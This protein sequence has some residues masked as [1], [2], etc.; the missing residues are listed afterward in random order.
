[1]P[2][3]DVSP[4]TSAAPTNPRV[5]SEPADSALT[6]DQVLHALSQIERQLHDLR[7]VREEQAQVEVQVAG[8]IA[9]LAQRESDVESRSSTLDAQ[10]AALESERSSLDAAREQLDHRIADLETRAKELERRSIELNEQTRSYDERESSMRARL[11][12]LEQRTSEL[13]AAMRAAE[14]RERA[15][16]ETAEALAKRE[17]DLASKEQGLAAHD[18]HVS[19]ARQELSRR[20]AEVMGRSA[21]MD[22]REDEL[23]AREARVAESESRQKAVPAPSGD[24]SDDDWWLTGKVSGTS[25]DVAAAVRLRRERLARYKKLLHERASQLIQAKQAVEARFAEF[26]AIKHQITGERQVLAGEREAIAAQRKALEAERAGLHAE[27]E[28]LEKSRHAADLHRPAQPAQHDAA[29]QQAQQQLAADRAALQRE[30][31]SLE[32]AAHVVAKREATRS[33]GLLVASVSVTLVALGALS[34]FGAGLVA[35]PVY[36][37]SVT[38]AAENANGDLDDDQIAAWQRAVAELPGDPQLLDLA[39]ERYRQRGMTSL[40]GS[41][42]LQLRLNADLDADTSAL[43]VVRFTLR[44]TGKSRTERELETLAAACVSHANDIRAQRRD[45]VPTLVVAT[46]KAD[47]Q[48]V[49]DPRLFVFASIMGGLTL[50]SLLAGFGAWRGLVGKRR[51]FE[52]EMTRIENADDPSWDPADDM[53][54]S[55]DQTRGF[56]A[57]KN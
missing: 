57:P 27:Q 23:R 36:L 49:E 32:A 17:S 13:T 47:E 34:W 22:Q 41:G 56:S 25:A 15:L 28:H 9:E 54:V 21:A 3:P 50:F 12:E 48:P 35:E 11:A 42:G 53:R 51:R 29:I 2:E 38:L 31:L 45:G 40:A 33:T 14:A 6:G 19:D 24:S 4:V 8:R 52:A 7:R 43:G 5:P 20:E 55:P 46:S 1:M 39:A 44:G 37:A 30:R 10:R 26:E 16:A 18:L